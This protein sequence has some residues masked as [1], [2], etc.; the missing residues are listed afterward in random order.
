MLHGLTYYVWAVELLGP[1]LIFS[2]IFHRAL[3]GLFLLAFV[4]MHIGFFLCLEI[5]LFP[6]VSILM[7][8]AFMPGWMWDRL[9]RLVPA[10]G[11][12]IRIFYDEGCDFCWKICRLLKVFLI[13]P[14]AVEPAQRD[15][16]AGALLDAHDSWV[17]RDSEGRDAVN[18]QALRVLFAASTLSFPLSAILSLTGPRRLADR[19]Y[20][21]IGANRRRLSAVTVAVLQVRPVRVGASPLGNT[22]AALFMVFV[23][24]RTCR[25]CPPWRCACP[26][27]S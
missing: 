22:L 1:F 7:N 11:A 17:V 5:G 21:R 6:F 26:T 25:P 20:D 13:L 16:R 4:T 3:R 14:A 24:P 10:G 27:A 19:L 2:P 15:A 18:S 8:L 9:G 23:L 12:N